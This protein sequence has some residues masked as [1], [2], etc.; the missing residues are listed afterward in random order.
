VIP[1]FLCFRR[2]TRLS[3]LSFHKKH[4][5]TARG[6]GCDKT[7]LA[8]VSP[9]GCTF[10]RHCVIACKNAPLSGAPIS[11]VLCEKW[12]FAPHPPQRLSEIPTYDIRAR[13]GLKYLYAK[14]DLHF[15]PASCYCREPLVGIEYPKNLLVVKMKIASHNA[16]NQF[17]S[18]TSRKERKKGAPLGF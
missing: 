12:G 2:S 15:I 16:P 17:E 9:Q 14:N 8:R 1:I 11:R 10:W 7:S 13:G 3:L 18:P 6:A 4:R 5:P